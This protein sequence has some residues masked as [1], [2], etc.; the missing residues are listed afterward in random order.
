[1]AAPRF[2]KL[3]PR[4]RF[5]LSPFREV[6]WSRCPRCEKLMHERKFA[7]LIAF[8]DGAMLALG[9][10]CR[11]CTP[12]EFIVAHQHE[13][14]DEVAIFRSNHPGHAEGEWFVLGTLERKTWQ[15]SLR[16]QITLDVLRE[17]TS[18]IRYPMTLSDPRRRWTLSA[19][20]RADC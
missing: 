11:Y 5:A 15:A 17:H 6:R 12:C 16:A 2:G 18:D 9:K 4:Y 7:L 13:I 14:E 1:M 19:D 8:M 3:R 10:T 20:A